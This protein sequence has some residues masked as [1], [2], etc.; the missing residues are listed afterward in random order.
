M[1]GVLVLV[2]HA[3]GAL[4]DV[5]AQALTLARELVTDRHLDAVAV[6]GG[7]E[8]ARRVGEYG[9]RTLHAADIG[10]TY[11]P[12]AWA[13]AIVELA[14]ERSPDAVVAPGTEAG[15]EV[16]AHVAAK[17][18]LPFAA[19]C[20]QARLG[21]PTVVTRVRWGGSLLEEANVHG[22]TA[23][24]T[25]QP[26]AVAAATGTTA[27][28][29]LERFTPSLSDADLAVRIVEHVAAPA[30]GVSLAEAKV[31][32][33]GGRGVGSAEGFSIVEELAGLLGGAVGLLAGRDERR[34]AAAYRPGWPDGHEDLARSL[35][36]VRDQRRHAAHRRLSRRQADPRH[37]RRPRGADLRKCRL[38]RDRRPP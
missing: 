33:S 28:A 18:D 36:S 10:G 4:T 3:D 19:N 24:L 1:A 34:L 26:H 13:A 31:V 14:G 23:L 16:M 6:G 9:V 35:H 2:E 30:G 20:V 32:V 25:V 12:A 29:T 27:A 21:A 38:R 8:L 15:N 5:S 7:D 37:Q 17:L 11:A 22:A